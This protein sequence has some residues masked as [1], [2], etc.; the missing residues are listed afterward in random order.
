MNTTFNAWSKHYHEDNVFSRQH[1]WN[2]E[3]KRG[4]H[5]LN[6]LMRFHKELLLISPFSSEYI[7]CMGVIYAIEKELNERTNQNIDPHSTN[8]TTNLQE[9]SNLMNLVS[10]WVKKYR[11]YLNE[12]RLWEE[13]F[14]TMPKK[15]L[16]R[17]YNEMA[18]IAATITLRNEKENQFSSKL[19]LRILER[20]AK[21]RELLKDEVQEATS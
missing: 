21:E 7:T 13:D 20:V 18:G 9:R 5:S 3:I 8:G 17:A 14:R 6:D 16:L 15:T 19:L 2:Q 1:C 11:K 12:N 4:A 10:T